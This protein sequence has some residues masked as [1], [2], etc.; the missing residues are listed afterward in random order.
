MYRMMNRKITQIALAGLMLGAVAVLP[1]CSLDSP[2]FYAQKKVEVVEDTRH[3]EAETSSLD[4]AALKAIAYEYDD[5]GEGALEVVVTYNPTSKSNT[6]MKA[7]DNA[8]RIAQG[9][10]DNGVRNVKTEILP[11]HDDKPSLTQMSYTS[12]TAQA[13]EGCGDLDKIDD[14]SHENYRDYGLGCST[15][16]YIARQIVRPKDLLGRD[17]IVDEEDGRKR[18]LVV[19]SFKWAVQ[20]EPME[21]DRASGD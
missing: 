17:D 21:A 13:P 1:A 9:L 20:N 7:S 8:A 4:A 3:I 14:S 10:R 19:E 5:H 12:F 16:T 18:G 6:A 15:E 2:T 11:I